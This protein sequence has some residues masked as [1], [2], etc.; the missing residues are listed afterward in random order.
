[1]ASIPGDT[2]VQLLSNSVD[3]GKIKITF[4]HHSPPS[5]AVVRQARSA[6]SQRKCA[7][8]VFLYA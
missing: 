8:V 6:D 3:H 5:S 4:R 1:V 2:I 7:N